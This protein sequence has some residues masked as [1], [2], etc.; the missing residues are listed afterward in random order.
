MEKLTMLNK[1]KDFF[2]FYKYGYPSPREVNNLIKR[3]PLNYSFK[4]LGYAMTYCQTKSIEKT[5]NV[6]KVTRERIRQCLLKLRRS[7]L[8]VDCKI[9]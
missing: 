3:T 5:A 9:R 8:D 1:I 2:F 7:C 4:I 6:H